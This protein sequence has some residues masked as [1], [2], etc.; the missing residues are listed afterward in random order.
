M[1]V[2]LENKGQGG[3][4]LDT[5]P[6]DIIK[7]IQSGGNVYVQEKGQPPLQ[8]DVIIISEEPVCLIF[9]GLTKSDGLSYFV[10]DTEG[11]QSFNHMRYSRYLNV[12]GTGSL[13][14]SGTEITVSS[15]YMSNSI[16]ITDWQRQSVQISHNSSKSADTYILI[17]LRNTDEIAGVSFDL[18][19]KGGIF[20]VPLVDYEAPDSRSVLVRYVLLHITALNGTSCHVKEL[21]Y[22][23]TLD[24][25]EYKPINIMLYSTA[26]YGYRNL[27]MFST[28]GK[29]S[30]TSYSMKNNVDVTTFI[31]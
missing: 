14:C 28:S 5:A 6:K 8:L 25:L 11:M 16:T 12:G 13:R 9:Y 10:W 1:L 21:F 3:Y 24:A 18:A 4:V 26:T 7:H 22:G 17:D 20:K 2:K 29:Y 15:G 31:L 27:R 19:L 23:E 30:P